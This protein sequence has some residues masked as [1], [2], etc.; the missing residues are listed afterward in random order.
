MT[1]AQVQ[2]LI[3][4]GGRPPIGETLGFQLVEAGDGPGARALMQAH[5]ER[6]LTPD[7]IAALDAAGA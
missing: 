6:S 2:G 4:A 5:I 1:L 7:V 3:A